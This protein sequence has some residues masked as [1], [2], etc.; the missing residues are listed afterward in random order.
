MD[1]TLRARLWS[2][3]DLNKAIQTEL[4][5]HDVVIVFFI[6]AVVALSLFSRGF[7]LISW[8]INLERKQ[9]GEQNSAWDEVS[10]GVRRKESVGR[11]SR[12]PNNSSVNSE[13][14]LT[15]HENIYILFYIVRSSI[16]TILLYSKN[17]SKMEFH[18]GREKS[19]TYLWYLLQAKSELGSLNILLMQRLRKQ[20]VSNFFEYVFIMPTANK[21]QNY[22]EQNSSIARKK[23]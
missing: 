18:I 8:K 20:R 1:A 11:W 16:V 14:I 19:L 17:N 6:A 22:I 12:N 4:T 7:W 3:Q 13:Y 9:K 15:V 21:R 2:Y 10:R 23:R 5:R